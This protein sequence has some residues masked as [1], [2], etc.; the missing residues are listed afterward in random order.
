MTDDVMNPGIVWNFTKEFDGHNT[1][2]ELD[3]VPAGDGKWRVRCKP[4]VKKE[5]FSFFRNIFNLKDDDGSDNVYEV[6]LEK[7]CRVESSGES[8]SRRKVVIYQPADPCE[9]P[10]WVLNS[11]YG[12]M[13]KLAKEISIEGERMANVLK[14]H[15]LTQDQMSR[16]LASAGADDVLLDNLKERYS[17]M[18]SLVASVKKSDSDDDKEGEKK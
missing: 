1:L 12:L 2:L 18:V 3:A 17:K 8:S 9:M 15:E 4:I 13:R 7:G 11:E 6:L 16:F 14:R 5:E 10:D